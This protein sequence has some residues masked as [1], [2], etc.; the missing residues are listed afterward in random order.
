MDSSPGFSIIPQ[1]VPW[2]NPTGKSWDQGPRTGVSVLGLR[3]SQYSSGA[4]MGDSWEQEPG[5]EVSGLGLLRRIPF[6]SSGGPVG[7]SNLGPG[8]RDR[9]LRSW[10]LP[11]EFLRESYGGVL[12][13][14]ASNGGLRTWTRS[15]LYPSGGPVGEPHKGILG[16]GARDRGLRTWAPHQESPLF[17]RE[18]YGGGLRWKPRIRSLGPGS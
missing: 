14:G 16:P 18:P 11:Q 7:K 3:I 4:P 8:A 2:G 13:P 6:Y 9:G 1:D 17:H 10:T 5:T 12:G 15:L